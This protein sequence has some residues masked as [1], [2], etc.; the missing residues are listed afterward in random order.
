MPFLIKDESKR[1]E[2]YD[3]VIDLAEKVKSLTSLVQNEVP[4]DE[5]DE[6]ATMQRINDCMTDLKNFKLHL[7]LT[8]TKNYITKEE[9][10]RLNNL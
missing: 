10:D 9:F 1:T 4:L 3:E 7:T 5:K 6:T 8:L 2:L